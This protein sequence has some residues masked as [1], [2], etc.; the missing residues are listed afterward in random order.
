LDVFST[1]FEILTYLVENSL[2]S[3]PTL[4]WRS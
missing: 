4:V 3:S 1:V 2:F